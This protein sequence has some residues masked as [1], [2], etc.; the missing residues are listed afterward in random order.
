MAMARPMTP[1]RRVVRAP[2]RTVVTR[3]EDL[4][5]LCTCVEAGLLLRRNPEVIARMAKNG[6]LPGVKQGQS[7][8][9][10]RDDLVAYLN[11]LFAGVSAHAAE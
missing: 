10:R 7:W 11:D 8:I 4:P 5:V 3:V 9:F 1:P 6:E 2:E